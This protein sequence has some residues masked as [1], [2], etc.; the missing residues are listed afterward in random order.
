MVGS[1]HSPPVFRKIYVM[2][3]T[4]VTAVNTEMDSIEM[5]GIN[6]IGSDHGDGAKR[7]RITWLLFKRVDKFV[8]LFTK[9]NCGR[10]SEEAGREHT[11]GSFQQLVSAKLSK[12]NKQT[13]TLWPGNR[14]QDKSQVRL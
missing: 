10:G 5:L 7:K 12:D 8:T 3:E 2:T 1:V 14:R 9:R 4:M 11:L 6:S 13:I